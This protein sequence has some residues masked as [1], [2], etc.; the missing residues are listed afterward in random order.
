[1][2]KE[3]YPV[4]A[5]QPEVR[6]H[7]ISM[8]GTGA[9]AP[10]KLYGLGVTITRTSAGLYL[11]TWAESPGTFLGMTS[12]LGADT[13]S[14]LV[15]FTLVRDTYDATSRSMEIRLTNTSDVA[16]DLAAAQ[17]IDLIVS[18]KETTAG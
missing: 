10:T 4:R 1:M 18:F 3:A 5:T 6:Q 9:S 16:T 14:A 15:G 12:G 11:L 8:V 13:P 17:Y 7:I 2:A